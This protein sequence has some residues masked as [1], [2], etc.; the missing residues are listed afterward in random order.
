MR[1]AAR[2]LRSRGAILIAPTAIKPQTKCRE[3]GTLGGQC[4]SRSTEY[5][6]SSF[7]GEACLRLSPWHYEETLTSDLPA[8][9]VRARG[10]KD[11]GP[12]RNDF[13]VVYCGRYS[14]ILTVVLKPRYYD[15]P[16]RFLNAARAGEI[17]RVH[18]ASSSAFARAGHD[19]CI[20]ERRKYRKK[21][22]KK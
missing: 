22:T 5:R 12:R 2:E 13:N 15:V 20:K 7:M 10:S 3:C 8:S 18:P 9:C 17:K 11:R 4:L 21:Q 14:A 1:F 19:L 6:G 16:A